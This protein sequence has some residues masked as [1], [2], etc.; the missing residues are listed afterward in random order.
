M[1]ADFDSLAN[2][3]RSIAIDLKTQTGIHILKKITDQSDVLIDT[4]RQG[5][6]TTF[7]SKNETNGRIVE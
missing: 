1:T 4:Y 2:G 3:K 6:Y 7:I 5:S